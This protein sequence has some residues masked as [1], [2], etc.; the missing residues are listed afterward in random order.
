MPQHSASPF[1]ADFA[2]MEAN[3]ADQLSA[4][5]GWQFEPKWDGF[6][7]LA[8]KQNGKVQ[9]LAKSGKPLGRYFPDIVEL[10]EALSIDEFVLDGELTIPLDGRLTFDALQMRLHPAANRVRKLADEQPATYVLFDILVAP[11][12]G[13][14][15][16]EALLVRRRALEQL[17]A[18]IQRE[19]LI[20]SPATTDR[21]LAQQWLDGAGGGDFDG[22]MA[23]RLDSPYA[24]GERRMLKIKRIRTA[25][26]VVGGFRYGTGS[27]LV[28]SLLLGLYDSQGRLNHVGFTSALSG[29][30]KAKLTERLESLRGGSGFTGRSP[31]GPSR[32]STERTSTY[33]A[34]EHVLVVEVTYDHVTGDRFRHGTGFVRWRPDKRPDQCG[35][36]QL[37]R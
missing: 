18:D 23:K 14:L 11:G 30:D 25:D 6:R 24:P 37:E 13:G 8:K 1:S 28:G 21:E 20:L 35:M 22:V 29:E 33:E 3:S 4:D 5:D 34:L 36:E 32:W 10:L 17:Y 15:V 7:C 2:P 26:C 31:G 19:H 9:L 12:G 16:E 27:K